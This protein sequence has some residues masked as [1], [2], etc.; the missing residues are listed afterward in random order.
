MKRLT[1]KKALFVVT[2]LVLL[3]G[4]FKKS[5][6]LD[7]SDIQSIMRSILYR[8]VSQNEFTDEVSRRMLENLIK[9][10]DPYKLYFYESDI[11]SFRKHA[12]KLNDYASSG[13]LS[14]ITSYFKL[15]KS[16]YNESMKIFSKRVDGEFDFTKDEYMI[17]DREKIEFAGSQKELEERWRKRIKFQLLNYLNMDMTMDESRKRLKRHYDMVSKEMMKFDQEKVIS[18]YLNAFS[19]ALDPHSAYMTAKD[20]ED[21][22]I[23]MNLKLEGIGA[24]LRSEDGFTYVDSVIPGG[25]V[26]KM[27]PDKTVQPNDKIIAVAQGEKEPESIIDMPLR[28]AVDKIRGKK[29]SIVRLVIMRKAPG[30]KS[31][32]RIIVSVERDQVVLEQQAA[33]HAVH[34]VKKEKS[35]V[36]VGYIKLPTFYVDWEEYYKRNPEAK[37]SARD[38]FNSIH[39]LNKEKIDVMVFDLRNNP[40]GG[41]EQA[42][43]IAGYF[44]PG[45]PVLQVKDHEQVQVRYDKDPAVYYDGPLVVLVNNQSASASEIFAGTIRDYKRGL[46]VAPTRTFGKGSVQQ[47]TDLRQ[48]GAVKI[49][50]QLFY[51]PSGTSNNKD[52]IVPHITVPSYSQLI[53][54]YE[55]DLD[56]ALDWTPIKPAPY[57]DFGDTFFSKA[58]INRLSTLSGARVKSDPDFKEMQK[59]IAEYLKEDNTKKI[60]LKMDP[61]EKDDKVGEEISVSKPDPDAVYDLKNDIFLKEAF[62]I[63]ADYAEVRKGK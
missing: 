1:R 25:P 50:I 48:G 33:K 14:F 27:D 9:L 36:K 5:D 63:A 46:I 4:C 31:E 35:S 10:T 41:L 19:S 42:E 29:G 43:L 51:Q 6:G 44:L 57:K 32:K 40:G 28:E 2:L 3:I 17:V 59:K 61:S 21:F 11:D 18:I 12:D 55:S 56:Y 22:R 34:T 13:D 30:E 60:S 24:V 53:N 54:Y 38:V 20:Y 49:T 52:G 39:A 62:N 16:R 45:G 8:H 7:G 37:M 47:L 15:F 26:S 58:L 23:S